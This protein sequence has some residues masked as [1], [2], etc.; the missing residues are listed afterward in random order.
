MEENVDYGKYEKHYD[1]NDFWAKIKKFAA[2]AGGRVIY[3]ALKLYYAMQSPQTPK[4]AKGV[5]LGA[6]GYFILPIDLVPDLVPVAGFTDDL[7][8]LTAALATVAINITPEVKAMA[9]QKMQDWFG[10][11]EIA[12][13]DD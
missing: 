1:E 9:R 12:Q 4:W 13:L 3:S 6:L 2:K 8:V 5:I 10:N 7:A 11:N